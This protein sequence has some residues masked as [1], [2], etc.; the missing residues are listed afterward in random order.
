[1]QIQK[2]L[3]QNCFEYPG[4][5]PVSGAHLYTV[6]HE[7]ENP[8]ARVL[9]VGP[10]A[11]E[12]HYS[13]IPWVQW[14][15]FL[16]ARGVECL[17]YDY[18]GIGESTGV[19]EEMSFDQWVEDVELLAAWLN[20]RSARVPLVLHGLDLGA[21][22]AGT[23][24]EK[25]SGDALLL[26]APHASAHQALKASLLRRIAMDQAF[27]YG[28]ERKPAS[29]YIGQLENGGSLE[30]EGY[31]WTTRLWLD[32]FHLELPPTMI[33]SPPTRPNAARPIR[34]IKLDKNAVPLIKGTSVGYEGVGKDFSALFTD[35]LEW[36]IKSVDSRTRPA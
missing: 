30:V 27:K 20:A 10:F 18:R 23:A 29:S 5:F 19:F 2:D 33:E 26:W 4:Y 34:S 6:L 25:A 16:A 12:R 13:Y 7:V 36:I 22:L 17:R 15:R 28:D 32:A 11:S 21:V 31:R 1:M 24:F 14:A 8:L 3:D 9:L 35:N